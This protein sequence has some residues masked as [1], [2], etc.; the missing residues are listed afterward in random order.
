V[1]V[2]PFHD[3]LSF[4][5]HLKAGG[6]SLRYGVLT[7]YLKIETSIGSI[8]L[9]SATLF[10]CYNIYITYKLLEYSKM[11]DPKKDLQFSIIND[12]TYL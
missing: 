2:L 9:E 12:N 6:G 7:P 1:N 5:V 10:C 4:Q 3:L 11:H 8:L